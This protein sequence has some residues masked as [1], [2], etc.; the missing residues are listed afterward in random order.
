LFGQGVTQVETGLDVTWPQI[1][2]AAEALGRGGAI[3][4]IQFRGAKPEE[5]VSIGW[6]E[7]DGLPVALDGLDDAPRGA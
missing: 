4:G 5:S 3:T 6:I 2:S 1:E 7:G